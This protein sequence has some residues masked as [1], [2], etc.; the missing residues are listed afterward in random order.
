M[1]TLDE[2][3]IIGDILDENDACEEVFL[4]M[5][6][7][8][9]HCPASRGESIREACEI[10]DIDASELLGKLRAAISKQ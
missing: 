5:G 9:T 8:C 10:H 7:T 3:T 2:D 6:M 4:S 1:L